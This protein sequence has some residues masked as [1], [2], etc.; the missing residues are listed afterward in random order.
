[1]SARRARASGLPVGASAEG[2]ARRQ[3]GGRQRRLQLVPDVIGIRRPVG[4]LRSAPAARPFGSLSSRLQLPGMSPLPSASQTPLRLLLRLVDAVCARLRCNRC[5]AGGLRPAP[6]SGIIVHPRPAP[7]G[8]KAAV[9]VMVSLV[10]MAAEQFQPP[11]AWHL[12]VAL[13]PAHGCLPVLWFLLPSAPAVLP[14]QA[15]PLAHRM[16]AGSAVSAAV[17]VSSLS[18]G[19][20]LRCRIG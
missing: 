13:A 17:G 3:R 19:V 20:G 9:G 8:S 7:V 18:Q 12:R 1:M 6:R 2:D 11:A 14:G 15:L 16:S 10:D 5:A 4:G